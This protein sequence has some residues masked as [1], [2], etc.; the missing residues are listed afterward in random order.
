VI[1][2]SVRHKSQADWSGIEH[3]SQPLETGGKPHKLEN[4]NEFF[5][6]FYPSLQ[7]NIFMVDQELV[8][9]PGG[10]FLKGRKSKTIF[11]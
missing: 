10:V 3:G 5:C 2:Q 9:R 4:L 7:A 8:L 6:R 1:S 11:P